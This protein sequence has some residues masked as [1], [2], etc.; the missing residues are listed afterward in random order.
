MCGRYASTLP[1]E[2]IEALFALHGSVA[3]Y[4][5]SWN[6]APSQPA[7]VIR[8]HPESGER[9][10]DTLVW[11]LLPH[12]IKDPKT[13][14]KPI[15]ARAEG[16]EEAPM[17]RGAYR[18]GRRCLVPAT[19]F[20]EWHTSS[21]GKQPYAVA[22]ADGA[23]LVLAGLWE[24]WRGADGTI[25]RSFVIITTSANADIAALHERMPLL[26]EPADWPLW[27]GETD[28]DPGALL[29]PAPAGTLRAWPVSSRVNSTREND[30]GLA[31]EAATAWPPPAPAA[32]SATAARGPSLPLFS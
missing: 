16:L 10:A 9:R 22:R 27:L 26:L 13:A 29:R 3:A 11:G 18:A 31:E 21:E 8:R 15:N 12:F 1:P 30:A 20:Y 19:L 24:G 7:L 6:I 17:F 32:E 23:P 2:Q 5:P 25:K 28:R 14:R 4:A